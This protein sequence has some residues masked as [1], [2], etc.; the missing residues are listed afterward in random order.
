MGAGLREV[1]ACL[2]QIQ[3]DSVRERNI[4]CIGGGK[5]EEEEEKE[6]EEKEETGYYVR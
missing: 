5:E 4:R 2:P 6:E 1:H 3:H